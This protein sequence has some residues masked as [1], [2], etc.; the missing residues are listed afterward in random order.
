M[1]T[2]QPTAP[3]WQQTTFQRHRTGILRAMTLGLLAAT[4]LVVIAAPALGQTVWTGA[5]NQNWGTGT[6]WNTNTAPTA[7][8]DVEITTTTPNAPVIDGISATTNWLR[9]GTAAGDG[10]L[11]IVNGGDLIANSHVSLGDNPGASGLLNVSG[12]GSTISMPT[13]GI[14]IGDYGV[15]VLNLSSDASITTNSGISLGYEVGAHG[16]LNINNASYFSQNHLYLGGRGEGMLTIANGGLLRTVNGF[17]GYETSGIGAAL[18][19][20]TGSRWEAAGYVSVGNE[21]AGKLTVRDGGTVITDLGIFVAD[22]L[23]S[24][25]EVQVTGS[26]SQ[27]R[28][29][30][31]VEIGSRGQGAL[32]LS[33]GSM[34][35]VGDTLTLA[36]FAPG[37]G[38]LNI[39]AAA[40]DAAAA[41][42]IIANVGTVTFGPGTGTFNF[43]H[44]G[45]NYTFNPNFVGTGTINHF[46]GTTTLVNNSQLFNGTLN[47][48]G[49]KLLLNNRIGG[50]VNVSGGGIFGGNAEVVGPLFNIQSAGVLSPGNSIGTV[51]AVDVTFSAGSFYDVE[52]NAAG[53]ADKLNAQNIAQING[54]MVR[55]SASPDHVLD[56]AYSILFAR[57]GV[58][59][60]FDK[61]TTTIAFVKPVLT[62]GLNEVFLT[63]YNALDMGGIAETPN[64]E[65]VASSLDDLGPQDELVIPFADETPEDTKKGFDD[66]S[67]EIHA[68]ISSALIDGAKI[69]RDAVLER[70]GADDE[71]LWAIVQ[72]SHLAVAG[73]GNAA[74][75][76]SGRF[77]VIGGID[78]HL[79]DWRVGFLLQGGMQQVSIPERSS[80]ASIGNP[81]LG[82]YARGKWGGTGLDLGGTVTAHD[83]NTT[84]NVVIGNFSDQL[85]AH[86]LGVTGQLFGR[87]SQELELPEFTLVPYGEA[88]Y[89]VTTTNGFTE[90]GGPAALTVAGTVN[91][92]LVTTLGFNIERKTMLD[93]GST[94][95]FKAGLGWQHIFAD[96]PQTS[97]VLKGQDF[98]VIGV[99][100]PQDALVL[101]AGLEWQQSDSTRFGL[102]YDGTLSPSAQ[103]HAL[104]ANFATEF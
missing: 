17:I 64:Q 27:L 59:G 13:N 3:L 100:L 81:G 34:L 55:V 68:S 69:P 70:S 95:T 5:Q 14:G 77:D 48:T 85:R 66:L 87:F 53:Q 65:E 67:G 43:N 71:Q 91:Q 99:G 1:T 79:G 94:L 83:I 90:E 96:K 44:T 35:W 49:G 18:I 8:D 82:A 37:N 2:V 52:V 63:L 15:G 56:Q 28:T 50:V 19:D 16:T 76:S 11:S 42:G 38:T 12:A 29:I 93:D 98:T 86:Y 22:H 25:G 101:D 88:A 4:T 61:V 45:S 75:L 80:T 33:G 74:A 30:G 21:G 10:S 41:P 23:G 20:G 32:T 102:A 72:G 57:S 6:N 84:R 36:K 39:G 40:G 54:G 104:K 51:N 31:S 97:N 46:A 92:A 24:Q 78:D 62:Y 9:I 103:S 89:V 73:D 47:V 60:T 7:A 26:G 58:T